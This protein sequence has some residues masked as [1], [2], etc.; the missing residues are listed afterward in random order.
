MVCGSEPC[1]QADVPGRSGIG[2][3]VLNPLPAAGSKQAGHGMVSGAKS[4]L[5]L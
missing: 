1:L 4:P 2:M 3:V 5:C